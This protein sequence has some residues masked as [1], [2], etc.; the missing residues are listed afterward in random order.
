MHI[1]T[2]FSGCLEAAPAFSLIVCELLNLERNGLMTLFKVFTCRNF[3]ST[4]FKKKTNFVPISSRACQGKTDSL[5]QIL[6]C[7]CNGCENIF[8]VYI[9][10]CWSPQLYKIWNRSFRVYFC[11]ANKRETDYFLSLISHKCYS[12]NPRT[13]CDL[14]LTL[15]EFAI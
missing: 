12:I 10:S 11:R 5:H 8:L 6:C 15:N 14:P 1:W 13:I 4:I 3:E 2:D 7:Q 9:S